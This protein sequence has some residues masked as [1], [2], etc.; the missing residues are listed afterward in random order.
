MVDILKKYGV[1]PKHLTKLAPCSRATA[2]AWLSD[3][4]ARSPGAQ[5]QP[6]VDA[7]SAALEI[8]DAEGIHVDDDN[9]VEVVKSL[10][11]DRKLL[12]NTYE[13]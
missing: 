8:A 11:R 6:Y 4:I 7:I 1:Q 13:V 5:L 9:L 12:K 3:N 10:V 2:S